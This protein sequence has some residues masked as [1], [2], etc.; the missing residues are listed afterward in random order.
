MGRSVEAAVP[1]VIQHTGVDEH[2]ERHILVVEDDG[3][4]RALL[5]ELLSHAGYAVVQAGDGAEALQHLRERH[6]HLIVLDLMLPGM[7]GWQFLERSRGQLAAANIPVLVLSAI[8][9][10]SDYPDTLG[11]AAWLTKPIDVERFMQ[12]V[13]QLA[14]PSDARPQP[15]GRGRPAAPARILLI[16]DERAI[17]GLLVEH[18][19]SEGYALDEAGSIDEARAHLASRQPTHIVL[20]LMLP[21]RSGWDFLRERQ[22]DQHLASIPVLVVSAAPQARLVEAKQLGADAF[23]SKPIDLDV[24]S[25]VLRSLAR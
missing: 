18:L 23:L 9:G 22:R 24:L 4:I 5:S 16:E 11:V 17:R 2:A 1:G 25:A 12:A 10:K 7:S 6:P 19:A 3:P 13:A 15:P 14:G 20:D 8:E 21:G